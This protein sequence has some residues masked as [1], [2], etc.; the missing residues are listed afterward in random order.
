MAI[1]ITSFFLDFGNRLHFG[2]YWEGWQI[3]RLEDFEFFGFL[4]YQPCILSYWGTG[5]GYCRDFGKCGAERQSD[6]TGIGF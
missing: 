1:M 3:S 6:I 5:L 4:T 2:P